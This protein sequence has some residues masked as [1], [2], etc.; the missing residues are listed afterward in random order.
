MKLSVDI[1]VM[2]G[3]HAV[4]AA[5]DLDAAVAGLHGPSGIGKTTTLHVIAGLLRPD[6]GRVQLGQRI[7]TDVADSTFVPAHKRRIG[8]VFQEGRL[9]PHYSVLGNLRY[10]RRFSPTPLSDSQTDTVIDLLGIR[11]LLRRW[12]MTLS[13]GEKQRVA[14][15]RALIAGPEMLLLDEPLASLDHDRKNEMLPF[16]KRLCDDGGVPIV[17]V[18][19]DRRELEAMGASIMPVGAAARI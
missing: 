11:H 14:I 16:L 19:H 10:G 1:K 18:S 3:T 5:F 4:T 17:Y 6:A 9:F 2:R 13:G 12:P 8:Y 15:G 7:L